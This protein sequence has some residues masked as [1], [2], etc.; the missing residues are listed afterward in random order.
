[1]ATGRKGGGWLP[2]TVEELGALFDGAAF[3][4]KPA[5]HTLASTLP[6]AMAVALF[7]GMREGEICELDAGD[8]RGR[9]PYSASPR[10]SQRPACAGSRCTQ[11]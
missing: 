11:S 2:F 4:I 8:V 6:W 10:R 5:R 1:M 9:V 7:S 3:E